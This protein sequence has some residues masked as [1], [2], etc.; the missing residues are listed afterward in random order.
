LLRRIGARQALHMRGLTAAG[1][2]RAEHYRAN[3]QE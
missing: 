2:K 1:E 3:L